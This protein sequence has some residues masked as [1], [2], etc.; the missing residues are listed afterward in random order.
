MAPDEGRDGFNRVNS[1]TVSIRDPKAFAHDALV[2]LS[3]Q[4]QLNLAFPPDA[5]SSL[6]CFL[7]L[8]GVHSG[9]IDN[10]R[11]KLKELISTRISVPGRLTSCFIMVKLGS[12]TV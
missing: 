2:S 8:G 6:T 3:D 5:D 12:L 1:L 11:F 7:D 10:T 9:D 4:F